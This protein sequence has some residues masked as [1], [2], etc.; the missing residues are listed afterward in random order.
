MSISAAPSVT[1]SAAARA[2][3]SARSQPCGKPDDADHSGARAR[4]RLSRRA[5]PSTAARSRSRSATC[6]RCRR[7]RRRHAPSLPASAPNGRAGAASSMRVMA[8]APGAVAR[9]GDA[10]GEVGFELPRRMELRRRCRARRGR[11]RRA[12][13]PRSGAGVGGCEQAKLGARKVGELRARHAHVDGSVAVGV[14]GSTA[15]PPW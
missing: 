2:F 12:P 7:R 3:T 6:A 5:S 1:A 14:A 15:A 10:C 4:E 13:A 9:A 11:R 8:L